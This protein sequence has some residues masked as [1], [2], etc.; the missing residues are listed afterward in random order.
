M[1][2]AFALAWRLAWRDL[3]GGTSGL[4]TLALCLVLGVAAIAG[5]GSLSAAVTAALDADARALLGG[6]VAVLRPH[7]PLDGPPRAWLAERARAL[8]DSAEM[9]AMAAAGDKRVLV[10]LKAVDGAYPLVGAVRLDPD[11]DLGHALD[12]FGGVAD[13]LLL[14]R[15]G[16]ALGDRITV[17]EAAF[18]LRA[19][20]LAEPDRLGSGF[21]LGPRV[22]IADGALAATGLVQTG[23]VIRYHTRALLAPASDLGAI[24]AEF[25]AAFPDGDWRVKDAR[26]PEPGFRRLIA[27][28]TLY[29]VLVGLAALLIGG[30]GVAGATRSHLESRTHTIAVLKCLGATP[31]LVVRVYLLQTLAIAALGIGVGL[32]L[33]AGLVPALAP[34]LARRL[35]IDAAAGLYPL[36][37]ALAA[38]TGLLVA[39]LFAL[40]PLARAG[41]VPAAGLFRHL[42]QPPDRWP[43]RGF[44]L[45]AAGL[46]G[47]LALVTVLAWG[48]PEVGL[49]FIAGSAATFAALG[50]AGWAIARLARLAARRRQGLVRLALAALGRPGAGTATT[51]LALGAGA[52]VLVAVALAEA[53][54]SAALSDRLPARA[55]ALYLIDIQ[56]D[57][58]EAVAGLIAATPGARLIEQVPM[59]RGRITRLDGVPVAEAEIDPGGRWLVRGD[60][61]VTF[62]ALPPERAPIVA[63]RWWP[64]DYAG[65]PLV[66]LD[67]DSARDLHLDVGGRIALSVLGRTIEAEVAALRRI[68]WDDFGINF[69]VVLSPGVLDAAPYTLIASIAADPAAEA[70]L[71]SALGAD[72]ANVSAIPVRGILARIRAAIDAVAAALAATAGVA[73][74]AGVLVLTGVIAAARQARIYEAVV[75]EVLG[76][77]R[78]QL[79]AAYLVEHALLGAAAGT[80]AL[81]AGTL[82]AWAFVT[83]LAGEAWAFDAARALAVVLGCIA[84]TTAL[85]FAAT[86]RA[87]GRKPIQVLRAP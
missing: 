48:Q 34:V 18:T 35:A 22:M 45:A 56:R 73:L 67:A 77:S 83:Q 65:P 29:L 69:V 80:V 87:L 11:I 9:R 79:L 44:I 27:N 55:P 63:G 43:P 85:G 59:L 84:I 70:A 82:A 86:W 1:V 3:R 52:T 39:V 12:D 16:I 41:Q 2:E 58:A 49:W 36:P 47:A 14:A 25:D 72:L 32:A 46:V 57:Q 23:S 61:G 51:V 10:E 76:A 17:G 21:S 15:L 71:V 66:S 60:R 31:A 64:A 5:V 8:S 75:L 24:V 54:L 62:A 19:A 37:L 20:L 26:D 28:M 78:R 40:W 6:D 30:V 68:D 74:A 13:P 33:G 38:V 42:V 50:L 7:R 4:P 53:S 81:A